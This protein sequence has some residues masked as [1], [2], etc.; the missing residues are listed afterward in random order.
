VLTLPDARNYLIGGVVDP[1][2]ATLTVYRGD[3]STLTV[4][5]SLFQPT[6]SGGTPDSTD[7]HIIDGGQAIQLGDYEPTAD[8]L[9][10]EGDPNYRRELNEHRAAADRGLG[11]ALRRLRLQRQ[12]RQTDFGQVPAKTIARIE[13]VEITP[14][15]LGGYCCQI[16]GRSRGN[17]DLLSPILTVGLSLQNTR[18]GQW[19]T[20][21]NEFSLVARWRS[22][23]FGQHKTFQFNELGS[24][25]TAP[26]V[27]QVLAQG[28]SAPTARVGAAPPAPVQLFLFCV[29]ATNPHTLW[30]TVLPVAF[31]VSALSPGKNLVVMKISPP[32]A[33]MLIIPATGDEAP[34]P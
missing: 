20:T 1:E 21:P 19:S 11:P 10:Y 7:F 8:V 32:P 5:L 24:P 2:T 30:K 29:S 4:P 6:G 28:S 18:L 26:G 13:R 12:L 14:P 22:P 33:N 17:R 31:S 3:L 34:V 23:R 16:G 25:T 9:F 27:L 15:H